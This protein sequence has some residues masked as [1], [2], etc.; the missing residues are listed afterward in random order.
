MKVDYNL[1]FSGF[2]TRFH[3]PGV[4]DGTECSAEDSAMMQA[5]RQQ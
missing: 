3:C 4:T 2:N 1:E 5:A